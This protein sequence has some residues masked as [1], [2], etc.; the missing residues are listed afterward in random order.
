[1]QSYAVSSSIVTNDRFTFL[2][3]SISPLQIQGRPTYYIKTEWIGLKG[4]LDSG[5]LGH[6]KM[7][8]ILLRDHHHLGVPSSHVVALVEKQMHQHLQG[9]VGCHQAGI[10]SNRAQ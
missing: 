3:S 9:P 8:V 4:N 10:S 6:R 7:V 2:I 1:M 5:A